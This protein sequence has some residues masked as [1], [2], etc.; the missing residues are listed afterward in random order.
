MVSVTFRSYNIDEVIAAVV[1]AG[2]EGI[3]WGG[4]IHIP[5]GDI[6]KAVY[7]SEACSAAGLKIFSYGSYY[8]SGQRQDFT[9]ILETAVSLG[10]PNIRLWAGVK[11][12]TDSINEYADIISDIQYCADRAAVF[13]MTIAFEYHSGTLTDNPDSAI[14]LIMKANRK[15][16]FLYW[17]PDQFKSHEY[18]ICALKKVLPYLSNV[19]VFTWNNNAKYPL[20]EGYSMWMNYIDI[21]KSDMNQHGLFLEFSPDNTESAFLSDAETL[22]VWTR[23]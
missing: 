22:K 9:P 4:D 11:G 8:R 10:A 16:I 15:N 14:E 18:N 1:R 12:S 19:H 21:I 5:H 3:E 6:K 23:V 17:Q 7:A 13:G 20:S 2:L